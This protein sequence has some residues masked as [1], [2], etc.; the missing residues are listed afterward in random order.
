MLQVQQLQS[1]RSSPAHKNE[2][3]ITHKAQIVGANPQFAL[4]LLALGL[5]EAALGVWPKLHAEREIDVALLRETARREL[6]EQVTNSSTP[7]L[8]VI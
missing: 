2:R 5:V 4:T 8:T 6:P 7:H 1:R 3:G